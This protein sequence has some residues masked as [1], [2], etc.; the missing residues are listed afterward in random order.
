MFTV[1]LDTYIYCLSLSLCDHIIQKEGLKDIFP[2]IS[3]IFR[4]ALLCVYVYTRLVDTTSMYLENKCDMMFT[5]NYKLREAK[6]HH[7]NHN[8]YTIIYVNNMRVRASYV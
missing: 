3:L 8:A 4:F 5:Y 1:Y 7:H 6:V 2:A